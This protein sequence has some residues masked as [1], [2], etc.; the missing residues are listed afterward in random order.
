M[1]GIVAGTGYDKPRI[2]QILAEQRWI[3]QVNVLGMRGNAVSDASAARC[4]SR[5][6]GGLACKMRMQ[7]GNAT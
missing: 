5:D 3:C 7:M 1:L 6:A 2:A 4:I